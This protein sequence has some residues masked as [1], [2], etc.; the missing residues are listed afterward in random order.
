MR[1]QTT[2]AHTGPQ[3]TTPSPTPAG[4]EPGPLQ[5]PTMTVREA[6][7]VLGIDRG[8]AYD[9][10]RRGELPALRIGRKIIIP[11]APVRAMLGLAPLDG[12]Q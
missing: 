8:A 12:G 6:A 10:V 3:Q 11:T 1:P 9:A 2:Q 5:R 7:A 4:A